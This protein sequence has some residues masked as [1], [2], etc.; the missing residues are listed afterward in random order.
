[1]AKQLVQWVQGLLGAVH[2]GAPGSNGDGAGRGPAV[3][4][5]AGLLQWL[6]MPWKGADFP[7]LGDLGLFP[8]LADVV[9]AAPTEGDAAVDRHTA[10]YCGLEPPVL[11][12]RER[13]CAH[14]TNKIQHVLK[15][16]KR[17]EVCGGAGRICS[18]CPGKQ[19]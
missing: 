9:C 17:E 18:G 14:Y 13:Y 16:A 8:F 19:R 4:C 12:L 11:P 3:H 5:T 6:D 1:M 15:K 10:Q 7:F 2:M